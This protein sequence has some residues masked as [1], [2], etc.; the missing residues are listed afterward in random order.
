MKGSDPLFSAV[1]RPKLECDVWFWALQF[2]ID[3]CRLE[4]VQWRET[5]IISHLEA[6]TYKKRLDRR[7]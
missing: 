5:K 4:R 1:A 6:M 2:K 7:Q 3:V